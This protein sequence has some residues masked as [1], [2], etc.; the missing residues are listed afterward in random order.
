MHHG[1]ATEC[2]SVTWWHCGDPFRLYPSHT[3]L[4]SLFPCATI[5]SSFSLYRYVGLYGTSFYV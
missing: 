5:K 2:L 4:V 1:S 3:C